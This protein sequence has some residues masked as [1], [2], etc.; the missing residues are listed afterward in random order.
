M[1]NAIFPLGVEN[2]VA[3]FSMYTVAGEASIDELK[4]YAQ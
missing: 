2:F 4:K 1:K 3:M